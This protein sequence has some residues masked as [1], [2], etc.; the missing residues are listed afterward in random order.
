MHRQCLEAR[1]LGEWQS[2][3][4][5]AMCSLA[6]LQRQ[7]AL[8]RV[9]RLAATLGFLI[10][11][12]EEENTPPST[13]RGM[14]WLQHNNSHDVPSPDYNTQ[15]CR[16][17]TTKAG[18]GDGGYQKARGRTTSSPRCKYSS[19]ILRSFARS[20]D[21]THKNPSPR[22]TCSGACMYSGLAT[23]ASWRGKP[24]ARHQPLLLDQHETRYD[25]LGLDVYEVTP[26]NG[27]ESS[28]TCSKDYHPKAGGGSFT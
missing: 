25:R 17:A 14:V 1:G 3:G 28:R 4:T 5:G 18:A 11:G 20:P 12:A 23:S 6:A 19:T 9:R 26:G 15:T 7:A 13:L 27:S 22:G 21:C 16:S 2:E 10:F 8:C 24:P